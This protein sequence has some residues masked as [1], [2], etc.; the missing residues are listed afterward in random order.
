[1]GTQPQVN[2]YQQ[3]YQGPVSYPQYQPQPQSYQA[4]THYSQ[5]PYV[6]PSG[7]SNAVPWT[8]PSHQPAQYSHYPQQPGQRY[9]QQSGPYEPSWSANPY[10][11]RMA[12]T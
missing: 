4:P 2:P 7:Q 9:Q 8:P 12:N 10:D 3:P 5:P 1:M 6:V 11:N